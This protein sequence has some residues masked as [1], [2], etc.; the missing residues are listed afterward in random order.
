MLTVLLGKEITGQKTF[1]M[2]S[3]FWNIYNSNLWI[4]LQPGM[5]LFP[6]ADWLQFWNV[7]ILVFLYCCL[8]KTRSILFS[9]APLQTDRILLKQLSE[10][11]LLCDRVGKASQE[12]WCS[13]ESWMS[14]CASDNC[15]KWLLWLRQIN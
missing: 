12:K 4:V 13:N 9:K 10:M 3:A 11:Y 14:A 15:S 1:Y 5:S 2:Q 8:M 7:K 6:G